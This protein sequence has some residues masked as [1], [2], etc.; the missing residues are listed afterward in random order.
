MVDAI[1]LSLNNVIL[2]L[3]SL[4]GKTDTSAIS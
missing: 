1:D 4:V 2:S 3:N